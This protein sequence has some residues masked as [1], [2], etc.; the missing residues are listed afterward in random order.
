M[1]LSLAEEG[2][3]AP[4]SSQSLGVLTAWQLHRPGPGAPRGG[5][6]YQVPGAVPPGLWMEHIEVQGAKYCLEHI[7]VK[8]Y[9]LF[10]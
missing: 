5:F 10:T 4:E 8:N 1:E 7:S 6:L 9:S 3:Q 2:V